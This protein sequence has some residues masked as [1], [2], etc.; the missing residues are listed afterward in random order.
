LNT[1]RGARENR[2]VAG[3]TDEAIAALRD[4]LRVPGSANPRSI[5]GVFGAEPGDIGGRTGR[6]SQASR[7]IDGCAVSVDHAGVVAG[8]QA[9]GKV[10]H[11]PHNARGGTAHGP[12]PMAHRVATL[13]RC[14]NS[15][16]EISASNTVRCCACV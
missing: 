16:A 5:T 1:S 3:R 7:S 12:W 15:A 10:N 13:G 8:V 14:S 2:V 11:P 9:A 6:L 4:H